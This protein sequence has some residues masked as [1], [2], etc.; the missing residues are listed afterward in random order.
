MIDFVIQMNN[1][2]VM[3]HPMLASNFMQVQGFKPNHKLTKPDVEAKGFA[4]FAAAEKPAE[5]S[6]MKVV[7]NGYKLGEDG[8]VRHDYSM[9]EKVGDEIDTERLA[10]EV[11]AQRDLLLAEYDWMVSRQAMTGTPIP[12][13]VLDYCEALRDLP[14]H[15]NFPNL[16]PEDWPVKPA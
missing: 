6:T 5:T 3:G 13:D 7:D 4:P 10:I 2:N 15:V 16:K 8:Y 9:V 14:I 11:R 1:G 12:Q